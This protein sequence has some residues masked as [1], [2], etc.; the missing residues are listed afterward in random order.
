M[1]K[2]SE[3]GDRVIGN[4]DDAEEHF[5]SIAEEIHDPS[6]RK[7][8]L[9]T[10]DIKNA[11]KRDAGNWMSK[12][13]VTQAN[14]RRMLSR[15]D[16]NTS[17]YSRASGSSAPIRKIS[18]QIAAKV[19]A[20]QANIFSPQKTDGDKTGQVPASGSGSAGASRSGWILDTPSTEPMQLFV[21]RVER[22]LRDGE[23]ALDSMKQWQKVPDMKEDAFL[24]PVRKL[25]GVEK[26]I[27][28]NHLTFC[29]GAVA[30]QLSRLR[31]AHALTKAAKV[32]EVKNASSEIKSVDR[33]QMSTAWAAYESNRDCADINLP[34]CVLSLCKSS[35]YSFDFAHPVHPGVFFPEADLCFIF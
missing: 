19:K 17:T 18:R 9:T 20:K 16:T 8:A 27:D 29:N 10:A 31:A 28:E 22:M 32:F 13:E 26:K 35:K 24:V 7:N 15:N 2:R 23:A 21:T 6:S 25:C 12:A 34:W 30:E 11:T 4:K 14:K 5:R 1:Q 3:V 33:V